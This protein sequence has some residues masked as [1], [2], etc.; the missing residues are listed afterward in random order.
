MR[1]CGG[2]KVVLLSGGLLAAERAHA[3]DP[4]VLLDRDGLIVRAH[5]QA[6]V[7][8]VAER[9][10]FWDYADTFAPSAGFNSNANWLEGYV[11]P[12][13][14]FTQDLGGLAAYGKVSAVAS[15]TLGIDAYDTGNTGRITLEEGYLGLRSNEPSSP[16]YD[17][18]LGPREFKAGTGMLLANG[19]SSG[20]ERGALKLGPRKAW[21]A[22]AIGRF[23][24]DDF[25]GTA[26]YLDANERSDT[27]TNTQIVGADFRYQ[28]DD[29]TFAG[30]TL[31]HVLASSA[32]YP[33]A[34]PGGVGAPS[35]LPDARDGLNFVNLYGRTNPFGESLD[36][37]FVAGDFAY[38]QNDRIDMQAWAARVQIGYTFTEYS[39]APT[40]TY[41]YQ[42]FSGD[43]PATAKLERFD[44]LFYE[45]SPSAWATGSKSS[46]VFINSNVN[47]H[48]ISLRVTPTQ[49]DTFTLR[50]A[51]ISANELRSPI[52]F[53]QAT[54]VE[55]ANGVPNPIAGVTAKHLSDDVFLEYNRV[56]NPNTYLTAG[57]S[58][59]FPGP[60]ADSVV[61]ASSAPVWTGGFVNV[62]VDF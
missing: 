21:E 37:F 16:S 5:L 58:V 4:M 52:Q 26:F 7:N 33:K 51:Y 49:R 2:V 22:A 14:S 44:P 34:A 18:S 42:T 35:V 12:S 27:D 53:G 23:G 59:S 25:T 19:G 61:N 15:G 32:P 6:G 55:N 41:S 29:T 50:Y 13:L 24:F 9:N 31:G 36:G 1:I 10:L 11:K 57:F 60:G 39:W 38:E 8:V 62:V 48:Q 20:F 54:R 46:M 40:L 30:A 28:P 43:D 3:D 45:G 17:I 56:L 47:A